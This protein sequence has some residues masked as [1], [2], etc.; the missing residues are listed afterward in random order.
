MMLLSRSPQVSSSVWGICLAICAAIWKAL[1]ERTLSFWSMDCSL[2]WAVSARAGHAPKPEPT[3][4]L[5]GCRP[6]ERCAG[7]AADNPRPG[8][9]LPMGPNPWVWSG[10]C[11]S[12]ATGVR[13]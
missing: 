2:R 10:A 4:S 13:G 5:R 8:A 1:T 3:L 12:S 6:N 11:Y 7:C 9:T